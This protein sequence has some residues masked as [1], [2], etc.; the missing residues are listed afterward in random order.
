VESLEMWRVD[1]PMLDH[2]WQIFR[3]QKTTRFSFT[4]C[5]II[6]QVKTNGMGNLR[7]FDKEFEEVSLRW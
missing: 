7:T 1:Q 2:S 6:S 4:D 3:N 5:T